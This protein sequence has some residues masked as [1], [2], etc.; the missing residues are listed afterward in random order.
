MKSHNPIIMI[1]PY[2][3][4]SYFAE[5]VSKEMNFPV[6]IVEEVLEKG[7]HVAREF[8]KE[9]VDCIISRG[10]TGILIK[11]NVSVPVILVQISTF[12][13]LHAFYR[14]KDLGKK[15]AF[16]EHI[17]RKHNYN[18]E[19]IREI[20]C[21]KEEIE[22]F[23]YS[24][25]D[26]LEEQVEAAAL[27]NA[28]VAIATGHCTLRMA[29]KKG[30]HGIMVCS[31]KEAVVD[32][33]QR[34]YD[35][36]TIRY[37]DQKAA[38]LMKTVI[39]NTETGIMVL[40]ERK[41]IT[42]FNPVSEKLL[43]IK[44]EEIVGSSLKNIP[45]VLFE[46]KDFIKNNKHMSTQM[47][48]VRDNKILASSIPLINEDDQ[49]GVMLTLQGVSKI[50]TLEAK[51]RKELYA[52][53]LVSR[54]T[55][56]DIVYKSAIM[57]DIIDRAHRYAKTKSTVLII[58]ESGTGKELFA[59][60]IHNSSPC[61]DGPF[62]AVNCAAIPENLLE[63]ELFGY[64]E[65]AF[66]GAKKG[67][68]PG[69]FELA[70]GGTIFLDE[71]SEMPLLL[72]ARLLR[73]L[74]EKAVRRVGDDKILPVDVR[75]I[76]ATNRDLSRLVVDNL[77]RQDLYFRINVLSINVPPLR[78][79][80]EDIYLL[81]EHFINKSESTAI[82]D[83]K[84]LENSR[85]WLEEYNWPGNIREMENFVEKYL[86]LSEETNDPAI[87]LQTLINELYSFGSEYLGPEDQILSGSNKISINVGTLEKM[88]KE[89]FEKI[90]QIYPSENKSALAQQLNISR[91][92]LWKKL[93]DFSP[94]VK[95]TKTS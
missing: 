74:Q 48:N 71:I 20:L 60:S 64:S 14:A 77:F 49:F 59:H 95:N 75:I 88:E 76:T 42:H 9:N 50:Q 58:G 70:H 51:I 35:L 11:N 21:L 6:T 41:K 72:Q 94:E 52:R 13:I 65:G 69:L 29:G 63:S 23:Y 81:L 12:D 47:L 90:Q 3:E 55:F 17:M 1:S 91:T 79:R 38:K 15:I 36:V 46:V 45:D 93:K 73:V 68:K 16:F 44:K 62:V 39:D 53:G 33:F 92:T 28:D 61:K 89:I 30:M 26:S 8:E 27:W 86:I 87:T 24:D 84:L 18:F 80:K 56:K 4:L 19:Q 25:V 66:T 10:A 67:G 7:V 57:K 43:G 22:I 37:K 31:T 54:Y 2:P 5:Q 82:Q 83:T 85:K 34:A 40:D 32:A 78:E